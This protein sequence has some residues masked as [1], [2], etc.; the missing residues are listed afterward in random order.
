MNTREK[1][2][3]YE[4]IAAKFLQN[5][6]VIIS[7]YNYRNRQG[8]IDIIGKDGEYIVFFEIKYRKMMRVG[9]RQRRWTT[10]NN[11]K[12]ARWQITIE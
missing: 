11:V 10:G 5:H 4:K 8:E 9:S 3:E 7:E 2:T 1:G 12:F 6:G